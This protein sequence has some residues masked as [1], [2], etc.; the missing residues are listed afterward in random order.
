MTQLERLNFLIAELIKEQPRYFSIDILKS[1]EDKKH[2][3]RSMLN[4]RMPKEASTEF[5]TI[6]DEYLQEEIRQKGITDVR[7]LVP[8]QDK[9]YLW[10]GD[11]TTLKCGAIVNAANS[12]MLGCFVP[13]HKCIDNAIPFS[14]TQSCMQSRMVHG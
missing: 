7:N 8:L 13:C 12:R 11:I 9:I 2:L 5:L 4:V 6:Q 3:L 14:I 10:Q 1:T